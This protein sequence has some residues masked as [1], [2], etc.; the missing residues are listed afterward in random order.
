M[1]LLGAQKPYENRMD[2]I[3]DTRKKKNKVRF[4]VFT[5]VAM[6]N[7]VLWNVMQSGSCKNRRFKGMWCLHQQGDKNRHA[8]NINSN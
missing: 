4:E 8:R 3:Y 6:K 7:T 1:T 2:S 5:A